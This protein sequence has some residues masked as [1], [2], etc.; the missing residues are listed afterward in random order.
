MRTRFLAGVLAISNF[1]AA[2][3]QSQQAECEALTGWAGV[4][5]G[6]VI[7]EARFFEDRARRIRA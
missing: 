2:Q 3:A 5:D 7:D 4:D 1:A 6:L